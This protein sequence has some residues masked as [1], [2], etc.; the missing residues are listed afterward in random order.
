[1]LIGLIIIVDGQHEFHCVNWQYNLVLTLSNP[2]TKQEFIVIT[3][4]AIYN[5]CYSQ[6]ILFMAE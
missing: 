6:A 1:M 4:G 3:K 5:I 2:L